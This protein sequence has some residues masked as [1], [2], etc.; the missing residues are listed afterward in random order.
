MNKIARI[1]KLEISVLFYSPVAWLVLVIF[2]IQTGIGFFGMMAGYK[3]MFLMGEQINNLTFSLFAGMNGLFDKVL[4]TLYLYIP[5]LTMGLMSR[6]VSSGTIRLLLSSPVTLRQIVLGKY[7]AMV[8]Y[9]LLMMLILI[10]YS[11]FGAM[12]IREADL[13]LIASGL[14]GLFLLLCTYASI[15]LFMSCLTQYQVVAAISTL[16]VFAMLN[17]VGNIGQQ[18]DVVRDL[19]YFLSISGRTEEMLKGLISSKDIFYYLLIIALFL[20]LAML[21]L[22]SRQESRPRGIVWGRYLALLSVILMAGYITSRPSLTGYRDMTRSGMR[23][24]T[25][26]SQQVAAAIRGPLTITTYVNLLDQHVYTGLPVARNVDLARFDEYRRFI[27]ELDMRYVYYYDS[28]NIAGNRNLIYQGDIRGLSLGQLAGK[29]ADNFELDLNRFLTPEQIRQ[30]IDLRPEGNAFVRTLHYNGKTSMLRL[31]N[32]IRQFPEEAEIT[33]AIKRLIDTVQVVAFSSGNNERSTGIKSER[34]YQLLAGEKKFRQGLL[35][36]GFDV[37]TPDL[38]QKD[39]PVEVSLLVLA[40][41]GKPLGDTALARIK[42][43]LARGGNMLITAEPGSGKFLDPVMKIFNAGFRTGTLVSGNKENAPGT[44]AVS[45]SGRRM[46][47][48]TVCAIETADIRMYRIDTLLSTSAGSWNMKQG[49]DL[50]ATELNYDS[51]RGDDKGE[52]PVAISLQK[53]LG[54]KLQ[55]IVICGDADFMSNSGLDQGGNLPFIYGVFNLFTEGKFPVILSRPRPT[56]DELLVSK[57]QLA[58]YR[59]AILWGGA[60]LIIAAGAILLISRK[61]N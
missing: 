25:A 39:L 54:N 2:M 12:V 38:N 45:G 23:T 37:V 24:L 52:Y 41:P 3:E 40:D 14:L 18:I 59:L 9:G 10:C 31:Y 53:Q 20:G 7:A 29:V 55:Q 4:Q 8:I 58:V 35:N 36:Q 51:S 15:G 17:Y 28:V 32:D 61:R 50:T 16:A 6:E 21:L 34:S 22:K 60:G 27:P 13:E 1:A 26:Q 33:T 46:M 49:F 19:T 11:V 57:K 56:D 42:A 44:I 5:L 47:M 48:N 30:K 43:Y